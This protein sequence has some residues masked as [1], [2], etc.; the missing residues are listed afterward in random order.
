MYPNSVNV[1]MLAGSAVRKGQFVKISS[2]TVIPCSAQGE[3]A[4][5]V[6]LDDAATGGEVTVC[7]SGACAVEVNSASVVVGS[8]LT[9]T[10]AGTAEPAA[11]ADFILGRALEIGTAASGGLQEYIRINLNIA[12]NVVA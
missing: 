6:A 12:G 11:S 7:I 2:A 9:T 4:F 3:L 5:G 10:A 1:R 8:Q